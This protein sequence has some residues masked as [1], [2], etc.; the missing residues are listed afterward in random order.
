MRK[1][2]S[3]LM[4][5][6]LIFL[7]TAILITTLWWMNGFYYLRG[8]FLVCS[9]YL[10]VYFIIE[11]VTDL[12]EWFKAH[13]IKLPDLSEKRMKSRIK[14]L[15]KQEL[16]EEL[17]IAKKKGDSEYAGAIVKELRQRQDEERF[18]NLLNEDY[19]L[20]V[21]ELKEQLRISEKKGDTARVAA[22]SKELE[23]RRRFDED[24]VKQYG[25]LD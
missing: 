13:P 1:I 7:V 6:A 3:V 16:K 19:E 24:F 20:S 15:S 23:E 2:T 25:P 11:K 10:A 9:L 17:R 4:W 5:V 14:N 18:N 22:I 8:A 12:V 21:D